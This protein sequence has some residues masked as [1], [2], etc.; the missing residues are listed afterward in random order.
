MAAGVKGAG[1]AAR[2]LDC[3]AR[4]NQTP[5][6]MM[7]VHL[8]VESSAK[9]LAHRPVVYAPVAAAD[10]E[11]RAGTLRSAAVEGVPDMP[12]HSVGAHHQ[13]A[14]QAEVGPRMENHEPCL[15]SA[16]TACP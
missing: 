13:A 15:D 5:M 1:H 10:A 3:L 9:K 11:P 7:M 2:R 12:Y 14:V 16:C 6:M 4:A 8:A